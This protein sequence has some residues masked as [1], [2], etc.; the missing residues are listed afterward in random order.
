MRGDGIKPRIFMFPPDLPRV[1]NWPLY[2]YRVLGKWLSFFIFGFCSFLLIILIFPPM[3]LF[4]RPQERF[5]KYARRFVSFT[6]GGFVKSMSFLGLVKVEAENRELYR[7]LSAKVVVANHPSILDVVILFSL[8]PNADCIVAAYLNR[9]IVGGIV[10]QLYILSSLDF[11]DI[12]K[13]CD[14]SFKQGNCLIIFPE[15]TRTPRLGRNTIKKGAARIAL[16]AGCRIVPVR[17]GGTD[18]YGLGKKDP[19]T[20]FNPTGPYVYRLD[21]GQEILPEH[22]Q[23]LSKPAAVRALTKDISAALFPPVPAAEKKS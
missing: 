15:G 14:E 18:K 21:M 10:R 5:K 19:W 7:S 23:N 16:A 20:G 17:I 12:L 4:F 1:T 6:L 13:A 11:D 9:S 8:I 3:R 22:Y 2:C